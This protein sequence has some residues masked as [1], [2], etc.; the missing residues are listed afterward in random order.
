MLYNLKLKC[1]NS[2]TYRKIINFFVSLSDNNNN[3]IKH[4][5]GIFNLDALYFE[6]IFLFLV[7]LKK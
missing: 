3:L 5:Y 7:M 2:A 4:I 1:S 6:N